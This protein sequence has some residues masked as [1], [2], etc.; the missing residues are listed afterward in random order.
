[1][2]TYDNA[3]AEKSTLL[4]LV[5]VSLPHITIVYFRKKGKDSKELEAGGMMGDMT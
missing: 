4:N 2:I 1:M 3:T 5:S